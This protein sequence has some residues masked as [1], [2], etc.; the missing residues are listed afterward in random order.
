VAALAQQLAEG[1]FEHGLRHFLGLGRLLDFNRDFFLIGF[2][3]F[4]SR[5][6]IRNI[7]VVSSALFE[8]GLPTL[9]V[10]FVVV[11]FA[12]NL[13]ASCQVLPDFG[14]SKILEV[15]VPVGTGG[16]LPE[17][18]RLVDRLHTLVVL[19]RCID[20]CFVVVAA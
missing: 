4:G 20:L 1:G 8:F 19:A 9:A 2:W 6:Q 18:G 12:G 17:V 16:G 10:E 3:S 5:A 15:Q 13:F 7:E 14:V 11:G